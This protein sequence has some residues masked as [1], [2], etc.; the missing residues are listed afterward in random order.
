MS[1][2]ATVEWER[3]TLL[4]MANM[5]CSA[6]HRNEGGGG[7]ARCPSCAETLAYADARA[8]SCRYGSRKPACSR[9]AT[10]C[11]RADMR[12]RILLIMRYAGP[13]MPLRHPFLT[14]IH[15][16][17]ALRRVSGRR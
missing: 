2:N 6:K 10:H 8:A 11:Y 1:G 9:C 4:V 13:R 12:Q 5:Y 16:Y 17:R 7:D 14:L 3:R 15:G